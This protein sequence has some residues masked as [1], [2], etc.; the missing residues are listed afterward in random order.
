[1]SRNTFQSTLLSVLIMGL[2]C[3][4]GPAAADEVP[5]WEGIEKNAAQMKADQDFI[6]SVRKTTSG[7]LEQGAERA[8]QAG[9]QMIGNGDIEGAIRRFNQAWLLTPEDGAIYWGFAVATGIR[10]DDDAV[11]DRFFEKTRS[12]LG[13]SSRLLCDWARIHEQ[14]GHFARAHDYFTQAAAVDPK[15]PEPHYGLLRIGKQVGDYALVKKQQ[16][17]LYELSQ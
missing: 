15:D 8:M 12:I 9:W 7:H 10:G 3:L 5:M 17:I 6:T 14:R 13:D 1:M 16:E 11:V 4:A 2:L